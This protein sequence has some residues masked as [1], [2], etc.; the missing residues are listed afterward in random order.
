MITALLLSFFRNLPSLFRPLPTDPNLYKQV[1]VMRADLKMRRGKEISQGA[2]A[3]NK[4]LLRHLF[5]PRVRGWL[6]GP[7]TKATVSIKSQEHLEDLIAQARASGVIVESIIDSGKT[8]FHNQ[9]T[10]TCAAFG[11]DTRE[12]I[13]AI[14]GKLDLR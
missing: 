5:D 6:A 13:D 11:P 1:I 9:K 10:L 3:S 8:E 7:F 2:H 4:V 14:T 12:R